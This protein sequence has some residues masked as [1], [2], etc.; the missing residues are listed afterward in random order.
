MVISTCLLVFGILIMLPPL[1]F[2]QGGSDNLDLDHFAQMQIELEQCHV[3]WGLP[4]AF[5]S[6]ICISLSHIYRSRCSLAVPSSSFSALSSASFSNSPLR[7][8]PKLLSESCGDVYTYNFCHHMY[9]IHTCEHIIN[10][11]RDAHINADP[12]HLYPDFH[13][14]PSSRRFLALGWWMRVGA[15]TGVEELWST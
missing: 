15:L 9:S 1:W 7:R 5:R 4:R 14:A 11:C 13:G 10:T 12:F 6:K 3:T 8:K 2:D